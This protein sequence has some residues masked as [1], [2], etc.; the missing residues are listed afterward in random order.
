MK[1]N[2]YKEGA[3]GLQLADGKQCQTQFDK[4]LKIDGNKLK[5]ISYCYDDEQEIKGQEFKADTGKEFS[6]DRKTNQM[7]Y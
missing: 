6:I 1:F 4:S 3:E 7:V 5:L 2:L